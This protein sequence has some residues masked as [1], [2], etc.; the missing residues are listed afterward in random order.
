MNVPMSLFKKVAKNY[1]DGLATKEELE[2]VF[3]GE[4]NKEDEN[5]LS[6]L[7]RLIDDIAGDIESNYGYSMVTTTSDEDDEFNSIVQQLAH[8]RLK[9][10]V[11]PKKLEPEPDYNNDPRYAGYYFNR[12]DEYID[13]GGN[14][15]KKEDMDEEDW[16][17]LERLKKKD[18]YYRKFTR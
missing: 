3:S 2:A 8:N 1:V 17:Q 16:E 6:P 5:D 14:F 18:K 9:K 4:P 10:G 13:L 12:P 15:I 7:E 11:K